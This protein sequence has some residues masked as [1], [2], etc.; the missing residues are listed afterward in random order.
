MEK[1]ITLW[2]LTTMTLINAVFSQNPTFEADSIQEFA[3]RIEG[4]TGTP[5]QYST[6]GITYYQISVEDNELVS[7]R[8]LR[9]SPSKCSRD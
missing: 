1:A 9:E 7:S 2:A 3:R 5:K 6:G 4:Q 8:N